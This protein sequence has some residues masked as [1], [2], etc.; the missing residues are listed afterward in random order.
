MIFFV[1]DMANHDILLLPYRT[2]STS[3]RG[4]IA[5]EKSPSQYSRY[6]FQPSFFNM[7]LTNI[8]YTLWDNRRPD[9][10]LCWCIWSEI[11]KLFCVSPTK[12]IRLWI[13]HMVPTSY[14]FVSVYFHFLPEYEE[15]VIHV[16]MYL[17]VLF[18]YSIELHTI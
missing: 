5:A 3:Y 12:S 14:L 7:E 6:F 18:M 4:S 1:C 8:F 9:S 10:P 17:R 11:T 2:S 13:R 16:S 15:N